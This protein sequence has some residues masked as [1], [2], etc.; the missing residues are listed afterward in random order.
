LLLGD[1][2]SRCTAKRRAA[3]AISSPLSMIAGRQRRDRR[4]CC[5]AVNRSICRSPL[6]PEQHERRHLPAGRTSLLR[7]LSTS[8][9]CSSLAPRRG[10]GC[11]ASR[12]AGHRT[13][14][15]TGW[16]AAHELSRR[17][18]AR[19][20]ACRPRVR[21]RPARRHRRRR[22][23]NRFGSGSHRDRRVSRACR[24]RIG[25]DCTL[26][27]WSWRSATRCTSTVP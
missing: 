15:R 9:K 18:R 26:D 2:S 16:L 21:R 4:A 27:S 5:A 23:T 14:P 12:R 19:R 7:Q 6:E 3:S 11:R 20:S 22:R 1:C 24:S 25:S 17:A 10:G 13:R 8:S